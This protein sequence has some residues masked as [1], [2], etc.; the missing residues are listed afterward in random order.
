MPVRTTKQIFEETKIKAFLTVSNLKLKRARII[1]KPISPL[2]GVWDITVETSQKP[3][4]NREFI[5]RGKL[6]RN[7]QGF[8]KT[9]VVIGIDGKTVGTVRTD[10][11]GE[12]SFNNMKITTIG[13]HTIEVFAELFRTRLV[14]KSITVLIAPKISVFIEPDKILLGDPVTII[15]QIFDNS[16]N[17]ISVPFDLIAVNPN[18]VE[19]LRRTRNT[20]ANGED[21]FGFVP[22][23]DGL[24]LVQAIAGGLLK[25]NTFTVDALPP[26][27]PKMKTCLGCNGEI[28]GTVPEDQPCPTIVCPPGEVPPPSV[29]VPDLEITLSAD[30]VGGDAPLA[31]NFTTKVLHGKSPFRYAWGFG[32]GGVEGNLA[33]PSYT[34]KNPGQFETT[35][36]VRD[37]DNVGQSAR[38]FITVNP[39]GP[40]PTAQPAKFGDVEIKPG[41]LSDG[42]LVVNASAA[43]NNKRSD[44]S[45]VVK[46]IL[47][48]MDSKGFVQALLINQLL[49]QP[50]GSAATGWENIHMNSGPGTYTV[51]F[52]AWDVNNIPLAEFKTKTVVVTD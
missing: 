15:T 35:V 31:V 51:E 10:R 1:S 52:F 29:P 6:L 48:I 50:S 33:N 41:S 32:D 18:G 30:K 3:I 9:K 37:A 46:A 42:G 25:E 7:N 45:I 27:P 38:L 24:W 39:S 4:L 11:F 13:N 22:A 47:Q 40:P 5:V 12:Y 44:I 19:I 36:S 43:L 26:P 8:S 23:V 34:F 17:P 49:L 21:R 2:A 14:A 28:I 20:N 16:D